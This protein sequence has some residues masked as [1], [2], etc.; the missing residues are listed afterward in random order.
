MVLVVSVWEVLVGVDDLF[1]G[2]LV[3]MPSAS[4]DLFVMVVLVMHSMS[5]PMRVRKGGVSVRVRVTFG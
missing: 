2:V 1:V 3:G 5:V 4:R